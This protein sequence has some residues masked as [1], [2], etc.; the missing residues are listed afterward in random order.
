MDKQDSSTLSITAGRY[1]ASDAELDARTRAMEAIL[2]EKGLI[3]TDSIDEIVRAYEQDIGPLLGAKVVARAWVDADFKARLLADTTAACAELGIGGLQGEHLIAVENTP[4]RHNVMVC[5]L[6]SCYP[7]PV[8]GLPPAFYKS[9]EYR[10]RIVVEPRKVLADDFKLPIPAD[11]E[12]RVYDVTAEER[13][14]V[15]P[16]RPPGTEG[17]SEDELAALVTRDCMIGV[18]LPATPGD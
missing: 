6:C 1:P 9:P 14:F 2:V 17:M 5:T 8:L 18:A 4:E 10:A 15:V 13:Y 16:E 7:W 3:G 12:I 11:K